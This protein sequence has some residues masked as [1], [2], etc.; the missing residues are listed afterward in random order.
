M[1]VPISVVLS[2]DHPTGSKIDLDLSAMLFDKIGNLVD[3]CYFS[4]PK[5]QDGSVSHAGDQSGAAHSERIDLRLPDIKP[6]V[7]AA[8]VVVSCFTARQTL[9]VVETA[10]AAIV[11]VGGREIGAAALGGM[12][13]FTACLV[14]M[15]FRTDQNLWQVKPLGLP[16]FGNNFLDTLPYSLQ[17][18]EFDRIVDANLAGE[19]RP[20]PAFPLRKGNSISLGHKKVLMGLGWDVNPG[21]TLD[22][23]ASVIMFHG[24]QKKDHVWFKDKKSLDGAVHHKGDS[25]TGKGSGDDEIIEIDLKKVNPEINTILC[26]VNIF[27]EGKT[28]VDVKGAY[29][30]LTDSSTRAEICKFDLVE[31][32]TKPGLIFAKLC[33]NAPLDWHFEAIGDVC[34]GHAMDQVLKKSILGPYLE[35]EPKP[36][37]IKVT[38]SDLKL[39]GESVD[40]V[41]AT[42][43]YGT[44]KE[45]WKD[46]G[47][48]R[49]LGTNTIS[50]PLEGISIEFHKKSFLS[51]KNLGC[52]NITFPLA[53]SFK[54]SEKRTFD[55]TPPKTSGE[56]QV[57]LEAQLA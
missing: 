8:M 54:I 46:K 30:R 43:Y 52:V 34:D 4:Q 2:W 10:R 19:R 35:D 31:I 53:D 1:N 12:G 13:N 50:G 9:S 14:G 16:C 49:L 39:Q 32:G 36:K 51:E 56:V 40:G 33:R 3:Q 47:D 41:Y 57:N 44:T 55:S 15:A 45:T 23:D 27:N 38:L 7:V 29:V 20:L 5:T 21:A 24:F 42:V 6:E 26:V 22:L 28:F 17:I 37:S 11:D 48:K 25:R 18:L